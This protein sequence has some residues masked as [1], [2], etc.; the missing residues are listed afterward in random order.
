MRQSDSSLLSRSRLS[1]SGRS[2]THRFSLYKLRN[3][4][5]AILFTS[6]FHAQGRVAVQRIARFSPSEVSLSDCIENAEVPMQVRHRVIHCFYG[7]RP[8]LDPPQPA[9]ALV[10]GAAV[11]LH[12]R[13]DPESPRQYERFP[14]DFLWEEDDYVPQ[15]TRRHETRL[16][17]RSPRRHTQHDGDET[18][19]MA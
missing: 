18:S 10:D 2:M 9:I 17:S 7:W 8:I 1:L 4:E 5:R 15:H 3:T 16:R 13:P 11:V 12:V 6:L 19:L 14:F